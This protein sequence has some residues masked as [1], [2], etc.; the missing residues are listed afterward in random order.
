MTGAFVSNDDPQLPASLKYAK[1][2]IEIAK[3]GPVE[4]AFVQELIDEFVTT[5]DDAS[6]PDFHYAHVMLAAFAIATNQIIRV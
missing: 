2:L 4:H 3:Q 5:S 1:K 6:S